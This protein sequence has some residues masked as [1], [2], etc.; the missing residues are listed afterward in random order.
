MNRKCVGKTYPKGSNTVELEAIR[1]YL[2]GI[3]EN[4]PAYAKVAPPLYS[5]VLSIPYTA[6]AVVDPE[7]GAEVMRLVHGEQDV[8]IHRLLEPGTT[9]ETNVKIAA[10][11]DKGSGEILAISF[12]NRDAKGALISEGVNRYF[13][14]GAKKNPADEKGRSPSSED[15]IPSRLAIDKTIPVKPDQNMLY[16]EGSGDFFPIHTDPEFA[17]SVGLPGV[18]L[19][20]MCTLGMTLKTIVD[21]LLKSDPRRVKRVQVRFSKPAV[22]AEPLHVISWDAEPG[23][24]GFQTRN[25][26]DQPVLTFGRVT[27]RN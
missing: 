21:A 10:I 19:H 8:T 12:E 1:K 17:K 22:P 15:P 25:S 6:Q 14:R 27:A 26:K 16:A 7:V 20:G 3:N 23:V 13:I 2:A 11:E 24:Y 18:I 4:G 9:F 5:A